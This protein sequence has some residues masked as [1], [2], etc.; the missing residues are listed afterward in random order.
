[1]IIKSY[2]DSGNKDGSGSFWRADLNLA[3]EIEETEEC[4][5]DKM[6]LP[7]TPATSAIVFDYNGTARNG[8]L[9][10]VRTNGELNNGVS[11]TN[12]DWILLIR[13]KLAGNQNVIGPFRL[14]KATDVAGYIP[15]ETVYIYINR[16]KWAY[17]RNS[18]HEITYTIDYFVGD[19]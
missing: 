8:S 2:S 6:P 12:A 15:Q 7:A 11:M 18:V 1:M 4:N 10:G 19:D 9:Q 16:F 17:N 13:G 5:L 3:E 14:T